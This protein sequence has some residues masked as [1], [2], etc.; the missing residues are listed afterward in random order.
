MFAV[1]LG[2]WLQ[3]SSTE[4]GEP[5]ISGVTLSPLPPVVGEEVTATISWSGYPRT[6][7]TYQWQLDGANIT[8]ADEATYTPVTGD[9][10]GD[11]TCY[12]EID[13]GEG[14]DSAESA[15]A[16]VVQP[17][18]S[19]GTIVGDPFVGEEI[20]VVG[21][22]APGAV[23]A[24]SFQWLRDGASIIGATAETY[25]LTEDDDETDVS[26]EVT[27]TFGGAS[28]EA[29]TDAVFVTYPEPIIGSVTITPSFG[30]NTQTYTATYQGDVPGATVSYQWKL[31]GVNEGTNTNTHDP[32][33]DGLLT[34]VVSAVSSGGSINKES[35]AAIVVSPEL[36]GVTQG[37]NEVSAT[38]YS[39]PYDD[40][41]SGD[42]MIMVVAAEDGTTNLTLPVVGPNG[43]AL[44]PL[45]SNWRVTPTASITLS[46]LGWIGTATTPA[47]ALSITC[48]GLPEKWISACIKVPAGDFDAAV[49]IDAISASGNG[50]AGTSHSFPSFGVTNANA[51]IIQV[52]FSRVSAVTA[53]EAGWSA[54]NIWDIGTLAG[55]VVSRDALSSAAETVAAQDFT[56]AGSNRWLGIAFAINADG[57]PTVTQVPF[58][59]ALP[60]LSVAGGTLGD[61]GNQITVSTGTWIN[62][63]SATQYRWLRDGVEIS[64][65]TS[66]TYTPVFDTDAGA[67]IT[68]QVRR[69]NTA[70]F[71]AWTSASNSATVGDA[72]DI[73]TLS[74]QAYIEDTGTATYNIAAITT[75][76]STYGIIPEIL[77]L[78]IVDNGDDTYT[79]TGLSAGTPNP[80]A[81]YQWKV[82]GV[83]DGTNSDTFDNNVEGASGNLTCTVTLTNT[84][85]EDTETSAALAITV[86]SVTN[87]V[88]LTFNTTGQNGGVITFDHTT[89]AYSIGDLVIIDAAFSSGSLLGTVTLSHPTHGTMKGPN[90][91]TVNVGLAPH[92]TADTGAGGNGAAQYWYIATSAETAATIRI[93]WTGSTTASRATI[94]A[95][96]AGTF[97]PTTPVDDHATGEGTLADPIPSPATTATRAGGQPMVFFTTEVSP[98]TAFPAGW[99]NRQNSDGGALVNVLASRDTVT[100]AGG[101]VASAN[102][103]LAAGQDWLGHTYVINGA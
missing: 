87:P 18:S 54:N 66:S 57:S 95:V 26:C 91:E 13:N 96:D 78:S 38:D 39:A 75:G 98:V 27:A 85:G 7:I 65:A 74:T 23:D 99:T 42:L 3:A 37:G 1:R 25:L 81:T 45:Q 68:A 62:S 16:T 10:G 55:A 77:S 69:E 9:I 17:I 73:A 101:A 93:A 34:C 64:G 22:T 46:A 63:P 30:T 92:F 19:P 79:I 102:F 70:G 21:Y 51:T 56:L 89:P 43:E 29:T 88:L 28:D 32:S 84:H 36:Y 61:I 8:G 11:L 67:V 97:D 59:T 100:T 80:T 12:V 47:G 40:Y 14:T 4:V 90:N 86:P 44:F 41:T 58:C 5:N 2:F 35:D 20:S 52:I 6:G 76:A 49:P 24:W 53:I 15:A 50:T 31:D 82:N 60:V 33:G 83:N 94:Y 103:D 48:S 71:G 72:P